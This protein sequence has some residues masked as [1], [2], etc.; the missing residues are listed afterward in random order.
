MEWG[1]GVWNL[2]L[3]SNIW[4]LSFFNVRNKI[5]KKDAS[6]LQ[7]GILETPE[8]K[9]AMTAVPTNFKTTTCS[10]FNIGLISWFSH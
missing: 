7:K 5:C 8:D 10:P 9:E 4:L 6:H 2:F 3:R 1:G